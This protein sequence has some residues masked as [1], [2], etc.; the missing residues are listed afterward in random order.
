M[1]GRVTTSSGAAAAVSPRYDLLIRAAHVLDPASRIN[2]PLDIAIAAG[3]IATLGR[4]IATGEAR[5]TVE[6]KG[7]GRYVVPGLIDMHAHVAVGATTPG[8]GIASEEP[9][10]IGVSSGV[11]TIGD[12]GSVGV[13]NIGAFAR[14]ILPNAATRVICFANLGT[15]AHTLPGV[16]DITR[17]EDLDPKAIA[18]CIATHPG[19]IRGL[20]LR[21]MGPFVEERGEEVIDRSLE[22][23]RSHGLPLM[24][25]IGYATTAVERMR[26]LTRR[27]LRRLDAGDILTHVCTSLPGGVLGDDGVP[28]AELADARAKGVFLDSASGR[29]NFNCLV[30]RKLSDAGLHPDAISTDL[31]TI[32]RATVVHSL[33]ECMAK[34]MAIGYSVEDVVRM[35]TSGPARALGADGE[36]GTI[37]VG[38]EADLSI[39]D[40]VPGSWKY[41]DTQ[42]TAFTGEHALV[43]VHAIRRGVMFA[44]DWGPYP[45]GWLPD[46]A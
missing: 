21:V 40:V 9:D 27:L 8:L 2:G 20:K 11:T 45:H 26:D 15:H 16:A 3:R 12:G 7:P 22:V 30:A 43:P 36:I 1:A 37:A 42:G 5:R 44:P 14:H 32:S 31:T 46:E 4:G 38:R 6:A 17:P 10:R 29:S 33:L 23:A 25:H 28:I 39:I 24:V 18:A 13:A 35:A 34:F 19:L 41:L